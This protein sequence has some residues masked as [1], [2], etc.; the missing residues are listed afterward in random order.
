ML[1]E[2]DSPSRDT[3]TLRELAY[4]LG[5]GLSQAYELARADR[6]PIPALR[7]GKQYRFSRRAYESLLDA[8]PKSKSRSAA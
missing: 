4:Q 3:M 2:D 6:L 8:E 5:I 1:S 7:V